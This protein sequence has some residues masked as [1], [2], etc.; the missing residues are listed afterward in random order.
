MA[1]RVP[2]QKK[3]HMQVVWHHRVIIQCHPG[4][5]VLYLMEP[6]LHHLP[7]AVFSCSIAQQA[8]FILH[9]NGHKIGS[10][11]GII[12]AFQPDRL[13]NRPLIHSSGYSGNLRQSSMT[14][15]L[16]C[17]TASSPSRS[18]RTMR[19]ATLRISSSFMPLV[20]L[21]GVPK[22]IPEVSFTDWVSKGM[23]FLLAVMLAR[24]SSS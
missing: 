21:A 13:S 11:L 18:S 2:R 20:V 3:D 14:C 4:E 24:S 12:E 17:G 15:S 19:E 23:V 6:S 8:T 10:V 22:R 9:T 16:T 5:F 1:A 7:S